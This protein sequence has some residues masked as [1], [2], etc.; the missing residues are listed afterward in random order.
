MKQFALNNNTAGG[1]IY[2]IG[3]I[4]QADSIGTLNMILK[5]SETRLRNEKMQEAQQQQQ[6]EQ[7][8]FEFQ[9][10]AK[11]EARAFEAQEKALDRENNLK[12][13]EIRSAGYTGQQDLNKNNINDFDDHMLKMKKAGQIDSRIELDKNKADVRNL[14]DQ[15]KIDLKRQELATKME[16]KEKDL[17]IARENKNKYD[18]G[19]K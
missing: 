11:Q 4:L 13:A 9:E 19:K 7:Q 17:A 16:M 10:K 5:Q 14:R 18:F 1:S 8:M 12:V 3:R 6:M 2:D 15:E